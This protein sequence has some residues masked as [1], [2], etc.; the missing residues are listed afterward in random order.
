M[1]LPRTAGMDS[2]WNVSWLGCV[3]G[4]RFASAACIRGLPIGVPLD[5]SFTRGTDWTLRLADND[6]LVGREGVR[7]GDGVLG[8]E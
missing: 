1:A 2:D 8:G 4:I 5:Q 6:C 3:G 7:A